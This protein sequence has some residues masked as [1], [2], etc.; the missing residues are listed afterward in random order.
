[1]Q[2]L[3]ANPG[4]VNESPMG[5]GWFIKVKVCNLDIFLRMIYLTLT[6]FSFS[7]ENRFLMLRNLKSFWMRRLTTST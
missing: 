7:D 5:E 1:M 3:E 6:H 4:Q 2:N